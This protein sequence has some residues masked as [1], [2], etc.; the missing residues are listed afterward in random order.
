MTAPLFAVSGFELS[1]ET[2]VYTG[3]SYDQVLPMKNG[4]YGYDCRT[5][6]TTEYVK[7]GDM[8]IGLFGCCGEGRDL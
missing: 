8:H 1:G 7:D 3:V 4:M 5:K 6:T 2:I